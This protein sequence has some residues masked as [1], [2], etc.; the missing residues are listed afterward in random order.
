[1]ATTS[2][3]ILMY[4]LTG[5]TLEVL[6]VHPGGPFWTRKDL[7]SWFVPKGELGSNE[8]PLTAAQREFKEETGID[9]AGPFMPLGEAKHKSGKTV[10]AWAIEGDWDTSRLQSNTFTME[11]PPRSGQQR[12]FPEIDRA[13]FFPLA[14]ARLK[15]HE[16]ESVFLD[17]VVEL[18]G[19]EESDELDT[20]KHQGRL[21]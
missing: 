10:V 1:M 16:A 21:F 2:A 8:D 3:G 18:L 12:Q 11:W 7:G 20:S 19:I 4:R 14:Q 15:I 9:V 6:L 13:E 17:R 5:R